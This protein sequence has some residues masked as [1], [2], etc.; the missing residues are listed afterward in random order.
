VIDAPS[1]VQSCPGGC[2]LAVRVHP[3]ARRNRLV[4]LH[5]GAL[6]LEVTA[7][8][9]GGE[10]NRVVERLLAEC[11]G[12]APSRASVVSGAA[13]RSKTV[14]ITGVTADMASR[15]IAERLR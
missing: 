6:K 12:V 8:P 1:F 9:E 5:A 3:K 7:A 10:A 13:S 15:R 11:L 4:G 2:R 14:E